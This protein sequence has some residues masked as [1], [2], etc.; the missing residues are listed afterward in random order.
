MVSVVSLSRFV[1]KVK[2]F[3][4]DFRV[5]FEEERFCILESHNPSSCVIAFHVDTCYDFELLE[6]Y[7]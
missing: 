7:A 5:I 6:I 1:V 4:F 2:L 3:E